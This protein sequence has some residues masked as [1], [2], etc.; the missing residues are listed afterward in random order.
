MSRAF[1]ARLLSPASGAGRGAVLAV[2]AAMSA[3]SVFTLAGWFGASALSTAWRADGTNVVTVELPRSTSGSASAD[4]VPALIDAL[5]RQPG[6]AD[7]SLLPAGE[8]TRL[9]EPWL[10]KG[11]DLAL[12]LPV[13][14]TLTHSPSVSL[15]QISRIVRDKAP[16]AV[17]E[18]NALWGDRLAMLGTSLQLCAAIAT[19]LAAVTCALVLAVSVV[20][21]LAARRRAVV[22]LHELGATDGLIAGRI[23]LQGG[24]TALAGALCGTSLAFPALVFLFQAAAPFRLGAAGT[25]DTHWPSGLAEWAAIVVTLPAPLLWTLATLPLLISLSGWIAGQI[26]ARLWLRRLP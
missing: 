5:S 7:V 23:A 13:I 25:T 22:L 16:D 19:A 2:I 24:L 12:S 14:I 8:A 26:S 6:L 15:A 21:G 17:I 11:S 9:M 3:L 10:G 1:T 18:E 4:S 20:T